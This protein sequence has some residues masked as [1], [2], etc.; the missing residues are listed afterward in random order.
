MQDIR[1]ELFG[2]NIFDEE[3]NVVVWLRE[4][5][6]EWLGQHFERWNKHFAISTAGMNTIEMDGIA[7]WAGIVSRAETVLLK[8]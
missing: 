3:P 4:E 2:I 7:E 5:G 8:V 1:E 6:V